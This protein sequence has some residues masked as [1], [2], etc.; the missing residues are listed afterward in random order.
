MTTEHHEIDVA[1]AK[2]IE[3]EVA[4]RLMEMAEI[5]GPEDTLA[6]VEKVAEQMHDEI[7]EL[8][9]DGEAA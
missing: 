4:E 1:R 8:G 2:T 6:Y 5:L 3:D 9:D 7:A